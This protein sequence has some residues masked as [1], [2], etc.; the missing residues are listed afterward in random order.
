MERT[1][2]ERWDVFS[3]VADPTRRAILGQLAEGQERTARTLATSFEMTFSAVSQHLR[4]LR[5]VG[6]VR[7][8][9]DGRERYY[10]L[11]PEPLREIYDWTRRYEAFWQD[12]LSRLG[13][14]L[15]KTPTEE[16]KP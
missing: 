8:R 5:E 3:A 4:V 6:L 16:E 15:D 1:G 9:A 10:R 12:R 14:H 7:V 11:S 2:H 13:T